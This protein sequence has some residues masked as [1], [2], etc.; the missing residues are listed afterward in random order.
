MGNGDGVWN[1]QRYRWERGVGTGELRMIVPLD[2]FIELVQKKEF[3]LRDN[4]FRDV[5]CVARY[6]L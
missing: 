2:K 4:D 3:C 5:A 1:I 6:T